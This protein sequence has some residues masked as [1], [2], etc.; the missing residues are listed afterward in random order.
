[1]PRARTGVVVAAVLAAAATG[2]SVPG[3]GPEPGDALSA[4]AGTLSSG[5]P[6]SGPWTDP[7]AAGKGWSAITADLPDLPVT[8]TAGKV[9]EGEHPR[10]TLHWSWQV[11]GLAWRYDTTVALAKRGD[12]W[13]GTWRPAVVQPSLQPGWKLTATTIQPARGDILGA[14]GVPIVKPRPE[15]RFGIDKTHVRPARLADSARRLA[16][17]V[18]ID[19]G[20]FLERVKA[21]GPQAFVEGIVFRRQQVPARVMNGYPHIPGASGISDHLPLAPTK[22]FASAVLGTVGPATAEIVKQSK[23]KVAP[24]DDVGLSGLEARYDDRLRGTKGLEVVSV[25][26][27]GNRRTLFTAPP[28]D[29]RPLRTTLVPRL[30]RLADD[31]LAGVGPA[32]ALVAVQ[33]ST[34]DLLAVANGPGA[35]GYNVATYGRYA[36]GST[37]KMVSSLALLRSGL[38]PRSTVHCVPRL[39]VN[40]KEFK[41]YSDYPPDRVGDIPLLQAVANSCNT[42]FIG[43]R[44]RLHGD[45]LPQAAAALGFGVDHD[46]GFPAYFGQVPAPTGET[47]AAADMIGQGRVLASPMAMATVMASVVAGKAVLPRLLPDHETQQHQPAHP[48]TRRE[49]AEEKQMLRAVVTQGSGVLLADLPGPPALAKTGTAEFG[50]EPPLPTHA[51]MVGAHGDL[52]VAVFVD[53][54]Q[55]GSGT[56]GPLLKRFLEG[57]H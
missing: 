32:S 47:E 14:G 44:G 4:L 46:L 54:G 34:G 35:G 19:P 20:S 9:T 21:A 26:A 17:L 36:P 49:D 50:T 33:P 15:I 24:G 30:Q 18:G 12:A 51:W 16:D 1:M 55:T 23:G 52:A 41:N 27:E 8:V 22:Q 25:D 6:A 13:K 10:G 40:G 37:F 5:K 53:R 45:D 28:V 2:C 3:S 38:T 7:E 29:G 56:A 57:A 48:L 31:V 43:E 39:D 42:A 11:Q